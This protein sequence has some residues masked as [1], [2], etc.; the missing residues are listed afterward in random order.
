M[1]VFPLAGAAV[2]FAVKLRFFGV[3]GINCC[4][5]M[6]YKCVS[7][8]DGLLLLFVLNASDAS[9]CSSRL[10]KSP[11]SRTAKQTLTIYWQ[12]SE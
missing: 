3:D 7:R 10:V 8:T 12:S 11:A 9:N 4:V 5:A 2:G 6:A 1:E